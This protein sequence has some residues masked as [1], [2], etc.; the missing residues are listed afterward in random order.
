MTGW[1]MAIAIAITAALVLAGALGAASH[2]WSVPL[3]GPSVA[4]IS[5]RIEADKRA[6]QRDRVDRPPMCPPGSPHA[7]PDQPFDVDRAHT[8]MQQHLRCDLDWCARKR[9]ALRVLVEAG[10]VVPAPAADRY[11][12][13]EQ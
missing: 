5:T 6:R 8:V 13:D 9:A 4:D 2:W 12:H 3:S 1:H 7:A 11:L 10:R